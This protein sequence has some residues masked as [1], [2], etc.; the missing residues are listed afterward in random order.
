MRSL[1]E[2][3]KTFVFFNQK[4]LL[5]LSYY[6]FKFT[7]F[8]LKKIEWVIGTA[9]VANYLFLI[10]QILKSN[11]SVCLYGNKFYSHEYS[12]S[13]K[14]EW[15]LI[16][17]LIIIFYGPLLLGYLTNKANNF[18]YIGGSGFLLSAID[19]RNFEFSFLKKRS[20]R[21]HC[22]FVGSEIRSAK[23][24][25]ELSKKLKIDVI[26]SYQKLINPDIA[27][28]L[29]EKQRQMLAQSADNYAST[30]FNAPTDQISYIKSEVKPFIYIY[31]DENFSRNENKFENLKSIKIVH[32]PSSPL[33]KGTP[34]VRAAIK[35]LKDEGY[36]FEYKELMGIPNEELIQEL[37]EAHIVLNEFYAFVPGQFG[38]EAMASY[39]ALLTSA[40]EL[41]ETTL[42]KGSNKAWLVTRYYEIYENLKD[43]L[44][45]PEKIKTIA[46]SGYVWAQENASY[47]NASNTL[48]ESLEFTKTIKHNF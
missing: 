27:S 20:K 29:A 41:I 17:N 30:I 19:G 3:L 4:L 25:D 31:P 38:V 6:F 10:S 35:K 15:S 48:N 28:P 33:I 45:C 46:D 37:R 1:R 21:V 12:Y 5:F 18:F 22:Y 39:C 47:T 26:S 42:S 8:K 40:D 23:L 32:A 44:D 36:Q 13:V 7:T 16:K 14:S 2:F 24:L 34:L 11:K 43:L 9:E